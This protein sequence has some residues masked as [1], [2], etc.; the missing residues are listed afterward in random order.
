MERWLP[1]VEYEGFYEVSDLGRVKSLARMGRYG[2]EF[3]R[4]VPERILRPAPCGGNKSRI[5]VCLS[6]DGVQ[7]MCAVGPLVLTSF[8]GPCPEGLV[9]RHHDGD[10]WNCAL[11][12]LS[13][14]TQSQNMLDRRLHGTD[15]ML[16]KTHCPQ[17]H[18]YAGENLFINHKGGRECNTCRRTRR[19]KTIY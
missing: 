18:E 14:D 8:V 19:Q 17:G 5:Q 12:N 1:V 3:S 16:N 2:S 7:R 4:S 13:W 15:P 6:R 10:L 11:T 9:C